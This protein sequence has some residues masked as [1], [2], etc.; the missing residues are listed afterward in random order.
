M[1]SNKPIV[2]LVLMFVLL[3]L[4]V[5]SIILNLKP[6]KVEGFQGETPTMSDSSKSSQDVFENTYEFVDYANNS[7]KLMDM[8]KSLEHAEK[9]CELLEN[10]QLQR[11]EKQQM[12]E[13]DRIYKE[14]Q[15]QDKKI[16]E[17]KEIVKYLTISFNSCIFLSCSCNSL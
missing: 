8:F 12:R 15:E 13:N 7:D 5:L 6:K 14:L 1:K 17:L 10:Q 11:E 4:I 9:K 3:F 2:I 16:H